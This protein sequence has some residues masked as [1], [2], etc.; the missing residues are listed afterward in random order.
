MDD[1]FA[2]RDGELYCEDV[3]VARLCRRHGT[4]LYV[5]SHRALV[6]RYRELDEA[7][8]AAKAKVQAPVPALS[9]RPRK[10]KERLR[11]REPW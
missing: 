11:I 10:R 7:K 8:A 9:G 3:P 2:Y 4:P 6:S 5:Y 1:A